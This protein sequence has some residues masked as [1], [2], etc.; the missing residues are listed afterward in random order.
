MVK[1]AVLLA[2]E[3]SLPQDGRG[4]RAST[5][6]G[7]AGVPPAACPERNR[8]AGA[9]R[10]RSSPASRLND[11]QHML[12]EA[13]AAAGGRVTVEALR[14][15]DVP[16]TTRRTWV[17]RGG[18]ERVDEPQDFT[19]SKIKPRQSPFEFEFGPAQKEA[20]RQIRE[21]VSSRKFTGMLLHC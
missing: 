2:A 8:R 14:G 4:A 11:N 21:G 1:V 19:I 20:L 3:A 7:S 9:S 15:L 13:L 12:I 17:K 5:D 16:H 18:V 6:T 10:P